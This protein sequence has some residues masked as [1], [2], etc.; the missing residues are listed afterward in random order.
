MDNGKTNLRQEQTASRS[1]LSPVPHCPL[2]IVNCPLIC[3][4]SIVH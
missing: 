3:P 2:S 4:L 1:S